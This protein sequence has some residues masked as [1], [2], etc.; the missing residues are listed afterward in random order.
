MTKNKIFKIIFTVLIIITLIMIFAQSSF[1]LS[2]DISKKFV[3]TSDSSNATNKVSEVFGAT[4][5]VLQVFGLGFALLM[6]VI[7]GIRWI[8]VSPSGKADI[9]RQSK[10]YILGVI[11]IVSGIA[12]LQIIKNFTRIS[13]VGKI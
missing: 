11:F 9:A 13:I 8:G 1:A 2:F 7:L 4:I 12:I 3:N 6:L 5:N 10:Y